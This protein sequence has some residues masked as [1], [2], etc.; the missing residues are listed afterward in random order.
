M[1]TKHEDLVRRHQQE[2]DVCDTQTL[3]SLWQERYAGPLTGEGTEA[4]G[5]CG[6]AG[7]A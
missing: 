3:V 2:L 4:Q 1:T 5:C 6:L 7:G